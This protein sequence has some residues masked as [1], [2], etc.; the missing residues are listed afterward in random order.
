MANENFLVILAEGAGE[1]FIQ[2]IKNAGFAHTYVKPAKMAER[3]AFAAALAAHEAP[4]VVYVR[5]A[6]NSPFD[7]VAEVARRTAAHPDGLWLDA[8]KERPLSLPEKIVGFLSGVDAKLLGAQTVGMSREL[9]EQAAQAKGKDSAFFMNILLTARE[10]KTEIKTV[11]VCA[12]VD[13]TPA[14]WGIL[15]STFK[16]YQVFIKFSIAAAIAYV[17]DIGT[18]YIFQ[19]VF[20]SL[21]E[22]F[23]LLVATVLS[24]VLCSIATYLL[25]KGA[26]FHSQARTT[27]AV[28]RFLILA[29][30]QLVASWLLVWGLGELFGGGDLV[31]TALK[32]VVDLVIFIASFTLQRDWVF[33]ENAAGL[34]K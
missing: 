5:D 17:V 12:G 24:R 31:H 18:F 4:F 9:A 13:E 34:L 27:G 16:L 7:C 32:V 3:D 1:G 23:K 29:V 6:Q 15:T 26:V 2:E 10:N 22:E 33:K 30:G 11:A 19:V 20:A 8:P 25:N 28:V 14:G 21:A